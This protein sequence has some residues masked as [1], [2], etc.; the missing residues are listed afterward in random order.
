MPDAIA[1]RA[2]E[3]DALIADIDDKIATLSERLIDDTDVSV[4]AT[5]IEGAG[6]Q[7]QQRIGQLLSLRQQYAAERASLPWAMDLNLETGTSLYGD[8]LEES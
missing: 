5:G 3:L 1:T 2:A 6:N 8:T 7:G 4:I